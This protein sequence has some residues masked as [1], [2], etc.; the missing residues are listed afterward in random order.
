MTYESL[1]LPG[2]TE[3]HDV[4]CVPDCLPVP[5]WSNATVPP[6]DWGMTLFQFIQVVAACRSSPCWANSTKAK[7]HTN[8]YDVVSGCVKPWT[9][10]TGCSIALRM[11]PDAPKSAELMV[12]H[13]WAEC[14]DQC[15]EALQG[16][17]ARRNLS[18][19]TVIWF[20]A[21]AQYQTGDEDG[22]PGPTLAEQLAQD[23]FGS[24]ILKVHAGL[25]MVVVQTSTAE[26]YSRL[27]CVYE[28]A[29]ALSSGAQIGMAYSKDAL[30]SRSGTFESMLRAKTS[31]ARCS[32]ASDEDMIRNKV[33][34]A[35]G[36]S[37]LDSQ[38]FIFRAQGFLEMMNEADES[39]REL[40]EVEIEEIAAA[41]LGEH[42]AENVV[43]PQ[44]AVEL[45]AADNVMELEE[46]QAANFGQ[47]HIM[48][49]CRCLLM[50]LLL[51]VMVVL[52]P[53]ACLYYVI[54]VRFRRRAH[55]EPMS[56]DACQ[57]WV[58]EMK[59]DDTDAQEGAED[60]GD[61]MAKRRLGL[62]LKLSG[63]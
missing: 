3:T 20:C 44:D 56:A 21:F 25:G 13:A 38:I 54:V 28:I 50:L 47:L 40:L 51:P 33:E 27:W 41:L 37:Q 45:H 58:G 49:C 22:D 12:S 57:H 35:G 36:F 26:V 42:A 39:V 18:Q 48:M 11:N 52:G 43:E 46:L 16:F 34:H 60:I 29:V 19:S 9:R 24:V 55:A 6:V 59:H 23:P 32:N 10:N 5:K 8:A 7:G 31:D 63:R 14:M 30:L 4:L 2:A 61:E 62:F 17:C 53:L 15:S 1:S